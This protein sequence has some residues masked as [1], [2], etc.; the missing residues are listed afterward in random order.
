[1]KNNDS[2]QKELLLKFK[3]LEKKLIGLLKIDPIKFSDDD[4]KSLVKKN[5]KDYIKKVE[6]IKKVLAEYESVADKLS[7]IN[8]KDNKNNEIKSEDMLQLRKEPKINKELLEEVVKQNNFEEEKLIVD[9]KVVATNRK[10]KT[11]HSSKNM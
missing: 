5:I 4:S 2:G 8:F 10:K 11:S 6:E 9:G 3:E 7:A 1:M